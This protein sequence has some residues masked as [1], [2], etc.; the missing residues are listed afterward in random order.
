M[1][2]DNAR[3][4]SDAASVGRPPNSAFRR[5]NSGQVVK[6]RIAAHNVAEMNGRRI[7]RQARAS[8]ATAAVPIHR[9]I[10]LG[11]RSPLLT[12]S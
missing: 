3:V 4:A 6:Q 12:W 5:V 1:I 11:F 7:S 2:A 8:T 10:M 9:S